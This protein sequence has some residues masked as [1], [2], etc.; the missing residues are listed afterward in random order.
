MIR[1]KLEDFL[2]QFNPDY[3]RQRYALPTSLGSLKKHCPVELDLDKGAWIAGGAVSSMVKAIQANDD[4]WQ[5]VNDFDL[6]FNV[7]P[8]HSR[9]VPGRI[10]EMQTTMKLGF[11]DAWQQARGWNGGD[12]IHLRYQFVADKTFTSVEDLFNSFDFTICQFATDFNEIIYTPEALVD[13]QMN[14]LNLQKNYQFNTRIMMRM[15]KYLQKKY[16]T[17]ALTD[18]Q[19]LHFIK[20]HLDELEFEGTGY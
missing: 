11:F 14:R 2:L 5:G 8:T 3:Q 10:T 16:K 13:L 12:K 6:F 7:L 4:I 20:E 1:Q 18:I 15:N 17:T 9:I 19:L